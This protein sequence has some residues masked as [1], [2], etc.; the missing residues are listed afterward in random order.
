MQKFILIFLILSATAYGYSYNKILIKAQ[1]SVFPKILL[2]DKELDKKLIDNKIVFIIAYEEDDRDTAA[3]I[4]RLLLQ[5]YRNFL[6]THRFE[7]KI[8]EFSKIS[9]YT[10]A[11]AIYALNSETNINSLSN[12]LY[13]EYSRTIPIVNANHIEDFLTQ[14]FWKDPGEWN[15]VTNV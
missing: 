2:L 12:A 1:A 6:S 11:T 10:E 7:T 14:Y 4:Q 8:V 15:R 3:Y 13:L 9:H 5:H